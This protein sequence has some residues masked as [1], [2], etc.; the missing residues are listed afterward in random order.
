M[1]YKEKKE[2]LIEWIEN[3]TFQSMSS[4]VA[5][6]M[7]GKDINYKLYEFFEDDGQKD[8]RRINVNFYTNDYIYHILAVFGE[9]VSSKDGYLLCTSSCRK[10]RA[11]EKHGRGSDI[12]DGNFCYE[13]WL[14]ILS[15]II[16]NEL[17]K[18]YESKQPLMNDV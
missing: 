13:T 3:L 2:Q 18:I 6:H 16:R 5:N 11:G 7:A 14:S 1:E 9:D 17:V 8:E 4:I 12:S 15:G 10:K